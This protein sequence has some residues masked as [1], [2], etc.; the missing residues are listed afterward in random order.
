MSPA[1]RPTD[2][3]CQHERSGSNRLSTASTDLVIEGT[4][5]SHVAGGLVI[6]FFY[7]NVEQELPR[8]ADVS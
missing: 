8:Q 4:D 5:E 3:D 7:P 2:H 6:E 1:L